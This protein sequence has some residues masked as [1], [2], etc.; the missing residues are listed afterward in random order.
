MNDRGIVYLKRNGTTVTKWY[1]KTKF[2]DAF[3]QPSYMLMQEYGNET[4]ISCLK[5]FHY[6]SPGWYDLP[7][8]VI[9][10]KVK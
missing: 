2:W 4:H 5:G 10:K 3:G 9:N 7:I 6:M 1:S 8:A